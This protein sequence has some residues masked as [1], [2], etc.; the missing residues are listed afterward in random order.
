MTREL[1]LLHSEFPQLELQQPH[2]NDITCN[3]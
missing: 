2:V 3:L 1:L